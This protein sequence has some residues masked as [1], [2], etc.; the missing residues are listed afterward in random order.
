[1][2]YAVNSS[3][4]RSRPLVPEFP[5]VGAPI[6][7]LESKT[8]ATSAQ[9]NQALISW[10]PLVL[11]RGWNISTTGVSYSNPEALIAYSQNSH[12]LSR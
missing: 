10:Q 4:S 6:H 1:M 12:L 8:L 11:S 9:Y 3:N 2:S 5:G 7:H